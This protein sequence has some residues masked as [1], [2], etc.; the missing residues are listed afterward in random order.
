MKIPILSYHSISNDICPLSLKINDFEK[1]LIYLKNN[2][3]ETI[4]FFLL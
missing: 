2:K 3:Y 4:Y 1:Q